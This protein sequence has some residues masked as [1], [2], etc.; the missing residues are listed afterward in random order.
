MVGE[1]SLRAE[2]FEQVIEHDTVLH[3]WLCGGP[4]VN[5]DGKAIGLNIARAGRVTT[6][7]LPAQLVQRI[8]E[9]LKTRF[10]AD[11]APAATA[12]ENH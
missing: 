10:P 4:L 2:G 5:L 11:K 6:Y 7:A 12:V 8:G 3:P 1:V 9:D